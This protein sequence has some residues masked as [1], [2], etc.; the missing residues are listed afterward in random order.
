MPFTTILQP[1]CEQYKELAEGQL[2]QADD[3]TEGK[4][5]DGG[6]VQESSEAVGKAVGEG[7]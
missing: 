2:P 1:G 3:A 6:A 4:E 5:G 7:G